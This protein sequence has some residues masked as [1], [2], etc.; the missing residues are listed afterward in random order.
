MSGDEHTT[1]AER[2]EKEAEILARVFGD[3]S[4]DCGQ[5]FPDLLWPECPYCG[6]EL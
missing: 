3:A 6:R 1:A 4:C 2:A 5:T